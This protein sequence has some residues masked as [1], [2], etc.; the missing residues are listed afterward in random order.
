MTWSARGPWP[1]SV[2]PAHSQG[3]PVPPPTGSPQTR[4]LASPST[5]KGKECFIPELLLVQTRPGRGWGEAVGRALVSQA[6]PRFCCV[7]Q[8]KSCN[9]SDYKIREQGQNEFSQRRLLV[10]WFCNSGS[11]PTNGASV[12]LSGRERECSLCNARV[13]LEIESKPRQVQIDGCGSHMERRAC[14]S[15]RQP[16]GGVLEGM[17]MSNPCWLCTGGLGGGNYFGARRG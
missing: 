13:V 4:S 8:D 10:F 2:C 9:L 5:H 6:Q 1:P 15:L 3:P 16:V 14:G 17:E 12:P 7:T 11:H